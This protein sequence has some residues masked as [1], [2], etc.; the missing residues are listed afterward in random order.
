MGKVGVAPGPS[1]AINI[2]QVA[3]N[4]FKGGLR[5]ASF[6]TENRHCSSTN[7]LT[8]FVT[9]ALILSQPKTT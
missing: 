3:S 9:P 7:L 8:L 6:Q 2:P 4:N 1:L 5:S